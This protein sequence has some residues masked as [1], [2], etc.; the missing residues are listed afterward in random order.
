MAT[1]R[2]HLRSTFHLGIA[3]LVAVSVL[4]AEAHAAEEIIEQGPLVSSIVVDRVDGRASSTEVALERIDLG[5]ATVD[6]VGGGYDVVH[7][8]QPVS[9]VQ[10]E[11]IASQLERT[12][13]IEAA[14]PDGVRVSVATND[15]RYEEQW[16]LPAVGPGIGIE[17]AW[18][19]TTGSSDL[20]IAVID[21]GRLDHPDLANRFVKGYDFVF[22]T[23]DSKDGDGWDADETDPGDWSDVADPTYS[24]S[25]TTGFQPSSWHGTHISGIIGASTNNGIGVAGIN[26]RARIQ[27]LRVLG[28]CGGRTSDEATAIRW[29]AGL[30]IPG[31]P[32][33]PTP[34]R[35]INLSL[36]SASACEAIEQDAINA[37]TEAGVVVVVA[38]GNSG[39]NL[40]TSSFA[41]ANC[42]NVITVA[43]VR[44]DGTRATY[45]NYGPPVDIAAPGGPSGILSTMNAGSRSADLGA[46]GW[47]YGYKQGTSMATPIVTG[48][49][50]LMLSVN[51]G[52]DTSQVEAILK[53]TARP[54][55]GGSPSCS[56]TVGDLY[57]CGAGM[58]DA[59]AAVALA[60]Q[61]VTYATVTR[62]EQSAAD[63][64][65]ATNLA[66]ELAADRTDIVLT[67]GSVYADGMAAA[68]LA[69]QQDA[70]I[71]LVPPTG[72]T[73]AQI[74]AIVNEAPQKVWIMGGP[75]AIPSSVETQLTTSVSQGGAGL[76]STSI[77]RVFGATR[78]E[79]ATAVAGRLGT[80]GTINGKRTA[81]IV[82]GDSFADAVIAGPKVAGPAD[83]VGAFPILLVQR[84]RLPDSV[85]TILQGLGITNV[86]IVGG[87]SVVTDSTKKQIE[88]LGVTTFRIAGADRYATAIALANF[89]T[90]PTSIGGFGWSAS[91][92][93]LVN[94]SDQSSGFDAIS[95]TGVLGPNRRV[96]LGL[97]SSQVPAA[98]SGWLSQLS[99]IVRAVTVIGSQTSLP[100]LVVVQ[101][102]SF[103][104]R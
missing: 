35:V 89:V 38:A 64:I 74:S 26:Q 84:D 7:L 91:T 15:P 5:D 1:P 29:A 95:A 99:G 27:H 6:S 75:Q 83:S 52:L 61:T 32:N 96:L 20:V 19:L 104:R 16:Y 36:G 57:Y 76:P 56:S 13:L 77:E 42:D 24:C 102:T 70:D 92:V 63:D 28:T 17:Q 81:F 3:S 69:K 100:P 68:A 72:L 10:A 50:S 67:S 53:Q 58:L 54:F 40:A 86:L 43:A 59:G 31:V 79:T 73:P 103:L 71:M 23:R 12:G 101:T 49:V 94:I 33:N 14:E 62:F 93:G 34:A 87:T 8:A 88:A 51:P 85:K 80:I 55:A 60:A 25:T 11:S 48:V 46:S 37:A 4:A 41:P 22:R 9:I 39:A 66:V 47:T 82:R 45:S 30:P 65:F 78:Y 98:T 18:S 97:T 44:S 90:A 2:R 21:T